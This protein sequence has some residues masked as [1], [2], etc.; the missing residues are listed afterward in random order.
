MHG[1]KYSYAAKL[2]ASF[3]AVASFVASHRASGGDA[4]TVQSVAQLTALHLQCRQQA[5][6]QD[7]FDLAE[8]PEAWLEWDAI[9]HVR[10]AAEAA[11][12]NA[13]SNANKLK[14]TRDVTVLRLIA[15]QPPDRV[16]VVRTLKLGATLKKLDGSYELDLSEPGLHKTSA[17]FG[18][19]RTS[20][21]ASI[22]PWLDR[23]IEMA[24]VP[25]GGYLFYT[26]GDKLSAVSSSVWTHRVKAT[27]ARHGDVALAP[28]DARSSF[29][30]FLRSGEHDDEAVK[31]AAIAMR[32][33]SKTQ[34][35]RAYDKGE[36]DRR[37]SA[38]MKV[39]SDYSAKFTSSASSSTDKV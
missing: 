17:V 21:N 32:H 2:A 35:S 37:V 6:Q 8:K 29:I 27:F 5:R 25:Q 12:A 13:K 26:K 24:G 39:A 10:V 14:L 23:Y 16:G 31:A 18:A 22:T 19:T 20:I 28:K 30:T 33:S 7:K 34:A 36:S 11:L 1:R 38:A 9:Q 4:P 3:V 15:D